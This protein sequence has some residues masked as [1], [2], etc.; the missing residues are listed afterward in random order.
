[1]EQNKNNISVILPI[2]EINEETK[3][4]LNAAI[5][6]VKRQVVR[7]ETLIIVVPKNSDVHTYMETYDYG[8]FKSSVI[9]AEND[10]LTDFASQINFG[11]NT[12]KTEWFSI[13]ELDDEYANIWFKN[14]VEYIQ[15][16][17]NVGIFLPI[18]I[19]TN[20]NGEFVGLTNEAVWAQ[21]F[22]D[23][24]G[25]LDNNALLT[26]QNFNIDGMVM[27]KSIYDSFGGLKP[28][29]KLM[30]VYEFL[31]RMTFKS[32]RT[33]VIPK[34]AYKH[35]N[36]RPDSLFFKYKQELDPVESRWWLA[37]AKKEYY[38]AKDRNIT[39]QPI[40]N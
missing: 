33:M 35:M 19:D 39:Y 13:L 21:S 38:F 18:I 3:P 4:L 37:Q 40:T 34:F 14:V 26:Y 9:I 10:G 16:H 22:S 30:F 36:L 1:M 15:K 2:H 24:L 5:E 6:S 27:K 11:V 32:V 28:S 7:P 20:A 23:E 17:N 8:D 29:V 12:C 25:I 31:L